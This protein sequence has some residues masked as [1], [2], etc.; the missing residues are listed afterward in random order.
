MISTSDKYDPARE[1]TPEFIGRVTQWIE[2]HGEVLVVL[3]YLHSGVRD[4][5]FCRAPSDFM[6]LVESLPIGTETIVFEHQQLAFRGLSSE[7]FIKEALLLI[8]EGTEYLVARL[9]CREPWN[10]HNSGSMGDTHA[11]LLEDLHD[12]IGV[13]VALGPC[14]DFNV[15][16]CGTMISASKG[17]IDG[18]R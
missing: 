10:L 8:P 4:F 6:K 7:T 11:C 14:P 18:P 5:L 15:P 3:R 13:E 16:D 9:Q 2:Q 1:I 17:G 12:F